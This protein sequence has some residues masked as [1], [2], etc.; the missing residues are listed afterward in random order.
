MSSFHN[1][2]SAGVLYNILLCIPDVITLTSLFG[3]MFLC[4]QPWDLY[5]SHEDLFVVPQYTI[6]FNIIRDQ[7]ASPLYISVSSSWTLTHKCMFIFFVCMHVCI[8]VYVFIKMPQVLCLPLSFS[9][10]FL[11]Q[12][13]KMNLELTLQHD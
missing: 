7:Q 9:I 4:P 12:S 10:L 6:H 13:L 8:F 5:C 3:A 11:R 2:N 1:F